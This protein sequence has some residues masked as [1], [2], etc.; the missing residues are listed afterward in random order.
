MYKLFSLILGGITM[1][2]PFIFIKLDK[3]RKFRMSNK[4][5]FIF[6]SNFN[7]NIFKLDF[8]NLGIVE[9]N[10]LIYAGLKSQDESIQF[11]Q[12]VDLIDEYGNLENLGEILVNSMENSSFLQTKNNKKSKTKSQ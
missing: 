9:I 8:D 12:V 1:D 4:A 10:E 3:E 5:F 7:K 6:Q 11:D 2:A